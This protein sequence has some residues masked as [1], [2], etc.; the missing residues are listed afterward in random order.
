MVERQLPAVAIEA[1]FLGDFEIRANGC[2]IGGFATQKNKAL[3]AYLI[4]EHERDHPRSKLAALF[5]PDV[6]EQAAL[7]NLRQALSVIR[8]AFEP[9]STGEVFSANR[10]G[11]GFRAGINISVDVNAFERQMRLMID[12]FYQQPGR[13]FPIQRLK[14]TLAI[15]SGEFLESIMLTDASMFTDWLVLRREALNRLAVEGTSL[16]LRYFENRNEWSEARRAADSLVSLAPWDENAH[17]RLIHILLRLNQG[18]AAL[19]HYRSA[20]R[21]FDEELAVEPEYQLK[22]AQEAIQKFFSGAVRVEQNQAGHLQTPGYGT[23]FIGREQELETLEDWVSDPGCQL[24]TIIGPGGSGKTR[25]AARLVELQKGFYS[26]GVFFVSIAGCEDQAQLALRVMSSVSSIGQKS[27]DVF[28]ELLDWARN[29]CALLVLDNVDNCEAAAQLAA[30]LLEVS[31]QLVLVCTSYARLDLLGERVFALSGLSLQGSENSEAFR[32]FMSHL[33]PESHPEYYTSG[34]NNNVLEI[35]KLVEGLPLAIDLAAGQARY[36]P[37]IELLESLKITMDILRSGAVN[38]QERHRSIIASFENC[39]GHLSERQKAVLANLTIFQSPFTLQLADIVCGVNPD[40]VRDLVNRSLL[41]WDGREHYRFHRVI[42]QYAHE[43]LDEKNLETNQLVKRHTDHFGSRLMED[44]AHSAGDGFRVFLQNTL[45]Y[46]PDILAAVRVQVTT[47]NDDQAKKLVEAL[48]AFYEGLSLFREGSRDLFELARIAG[49]N[50]P[51]RAMLL[52]RVSSLLISTHQY[53]KADEALESAIKIAQENG[54]RA[55]LGFCFNVLSKKAALKKSSSLS[56]EYAQKAL[57][58]A[59]ATGDKKEEAHSLYNIGYALTNLSEI[60]K[61]EQALESCRKI[62]EEQKDWRRL[63]KVLN[64]MADTACHRGYFTEALSYYDEAIKIAIS[65]GNKYT[66]SLILNNIGTAY[67]SID[68]YKEAEEAYTKSLELCRE[69]DDREGEAIAFSNLGELFAEIKDFKKGAEFNQQALVI[70][71]EI[72]SD[73]GE[74]SA[75]V[76]LAICYHELGNIP[77]ARQEVITVLQRSLELEFIYFFNRAVVEAC[78]LLLV[79][80]ITQGLRDVIAVITEDEESDDWVRDQ[81]KEVL[82][83]LPHSDMPLQA[84]QGRREIRDF[85]VSALNS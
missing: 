57:E 44:Y 31:R 7:H 28:E 27:T 22:N 52:A 43:E 19:A 30:E 48:Y 62:C 80:G 74:M 36:T 54:N 13:G 46:L 10:E 37:S 17:S 55:E 33:Q 2:R 25:L 60:T 47:Q 9:C 67:F 35:C 26:G 23:P 84:L 51:I 65:L 1:K 21:Y 66:Q 78:K 85:L 70:S 50:N 3:A 20:A 32:L 12:R 8:K 49:E 29:R 63:A 38:L 71:R 24:V 34:F 83:S 58:I 76:I 40:E 4:L 75:R 6:E 42:F 53:E 11:V 59:Q 56:L 16:L 72:G 39:R 5:W 61:A 73:W 69:I 45:A 64:V 18:N 14:R 79:R 15:Y 68:K 77:A 41:I 81:A 82:D